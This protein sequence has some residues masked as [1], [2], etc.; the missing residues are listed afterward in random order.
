MTATGRY[1]AFA[2]VGAGRLWLAVG[3]GL[4]ST[5][6]PDSSLVASSAYLAI[7][8]AGTGL[9]LQMADTMAQTP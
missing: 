5:V 1:K 9:A 2:V 4:L 3:M 6:D 7:V 8:G